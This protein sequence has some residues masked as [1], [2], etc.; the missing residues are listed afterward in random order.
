MKFLQARWTFLGPGSEEK[1][2][3]DAHD[4]K[5]QWNCTPNKMVQLYQLRIRES[6]QLKT[7][8]ELYDMEIHQKI[9]VP[10]HQKLKTMVKRSIEQKLRL[11]N[12]E[13][14]H[15]RIESAAVVKNRKG[16]IVVEG[17]KGICHQWKEKGWCSQGD[18]CSFRHEAQ[19][20]AQ[21]P[22]HTAATHSEP[23]ASRG[24]SVSR[25]RRIRGK[26]NH[27]SFFRQPCRYFLK[28]SC[29]R[30]PCEYWHPPEC[31]FYKTETV[32]KAGDK[33]LFPHQEVGE[34]S[35]KKPKKGCFP[36]RRESEDKGAVAILTSVSQLGCSS[37]SMDP[38]V[39]VQNKNF[40][41][42]SKELAKVPGA[43]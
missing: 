2:Y 14:R 34:Q 27:G 40:T 24:R 11:R 41:G 28:G 13:A 12:F 5:G 33:C 18:R 21:K 4:Q 35:N 43:R 6:D 36:K 16:I 10:N 22:E 19:D 29:T 3:G 30:T 7:V 26:S 23:P 32:C 20:R 38:S 25:K 1:W 9:S 15:G 42:N 31:Q 17:G 37:H 8:L 39:S